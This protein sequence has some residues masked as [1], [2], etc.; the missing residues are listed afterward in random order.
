MHNIV[1][2]QSSCQEIQDIEERK[3]ESGG[4]IENKDAIGKLL[5][6]IHIWFPVFGT[7]NLILN[8]ITLVEHVIEAIQCAYIQMY[9]YLLCLVWVFC[10]HVLNRNL[11]LHCHEAGGSQRR[12]ITR[13][14]SNVL[15]L[16]LQYS[17][18]TQDQ[19]CVKSVIF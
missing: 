12:R 17:P 16:S 3:K 11:V 14:R 10:V 2:D 15:T 19:M 6:V 5:C 1:C 4:Q 9:L 8:K 13:E 7:H 18:K